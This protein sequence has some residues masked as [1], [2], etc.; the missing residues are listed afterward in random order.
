MHRMT[1]NELRLDMVIS[2]AS[3]L[4][5]QTD[6]GHF[7]RSIHPAH[8]EPSIYIPAGTLKGALRRASEHVFHSA[9]LDICTSD[10]PC[11]ERDAVKRARSS[12]EIYRT[13]CSACKIF[14]SAVM[15]SH[16]TVTD[17]FPE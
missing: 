6:D 7:V 10:Q 5:I 15:R 1:C 9:G 13:L 4:S 12:A 14:G 2:T 3:P 16:L 8:G 17:A 11:S